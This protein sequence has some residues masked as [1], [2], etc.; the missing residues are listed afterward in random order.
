MTAQEQ[1]SFRT[2][3]TLASQEEIRSRVQAPGTGITPEKFF[4]NV[5]TKSC[6][7][8][9]FGQKMVRSAVHNA[10]LNTLTHGN[11]VPIRS[12]SFSTVTRSHLK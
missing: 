10:F 1:W 6:T 7:Q 11:D 8:V 3:G 5:Y 9:Y 2:T 4:G 12:G